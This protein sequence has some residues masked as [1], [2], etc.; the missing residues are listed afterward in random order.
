MN[1]RKRSFLSLFISPSVFFPL[2]AKAETKQLPHF[3]PLPSIQAARH[4]LSLFYP[5][6]WRGAHQQRPISRVLILARIESR[7]TKKNFDRVELKTPY[8][9]QAHNRQAFQAQFTRETWR[10]TPGHAGTF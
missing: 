3:I 4:I 5:A 6:L 10:N 1:K 2:P 9:S 7:Y 8:L